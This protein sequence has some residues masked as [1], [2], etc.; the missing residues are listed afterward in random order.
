MMHIEAY[1]QARMGSTRLPGKVLKK[2]LGKPV[3]EFLVERLSEAKEIDDIIIL[4]STLAADDAIAMFCQEKKIACFRGSEEDVLDRYYQAAL[5]RGPEGVVR[6]TADCP[7]I[8]PD[9]VDQVVK[10]FRQDF[11]KIDYVS[12]SLERTFPRGLDVEVFSFNALQQA[13]KH[14][15]R[16][17]ERE[18]VTVY[19]YR[20]PE[21]FQL[22]NVA[23]IPSLAHHRWTV[24]TPE[25]FALIRLILENLYPFNPQFRLKDVLQLLAQHPAWSQLNAHIEQKKLPQI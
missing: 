2:I 23:H 13:F 17:E 3:L 21:L 15:I 16:P 6:I 10:T 14:A 22:K 4:T 24:D 7:L 25:D 12:N 19:L 1:I 18:H 9:I 20:H 8:D 5:E 11:P